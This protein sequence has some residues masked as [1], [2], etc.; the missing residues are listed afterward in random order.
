MRPSAKPFIALA[1][2]SVVLLLAVISPASAADAAAGPDVVT[3]PETEKRFPPLTVPEGFHATL[4]ACDPL[5][6]YPSVISVG[7]APGT[8]FVAHDYVT[9]LGVEI[10]RRDEIRLLRD[11]NGDGYA[12]QSTL[13]AGGFNSIQGL[14]WHGGTVY[15]MH[16]PLLTALR[17]TNSDGVA[18]ERRDLIRGLGLPPEENDNRLHCA[19][20]VAVGHDGWLYLALGDR[21]CDVVRP[22]GD[23]L[24]FQEGGILRCRAGGKLE[25]GRDL[26]VFSRGLRNIYDVAL[27]ADLNVFVRDNENDGG[28]Y[29][30]RVCHCFHGSNHGYPYLYRETPQEAMRPLA[31]LGRGSSAGGAAYLEAAFPED[32]RHSLF[33]CEWG[34]AVVRYPQQRSGSSFEPMREFDFAAGA[35]NDPYGFKPTDV[36][37]DRDGS[38][39]ISD[40]GDGQRPKRGRGRIYR[41]AYGAAAPAT[42]VPA[43]VAASVVTGESAL[44]ELL[45]RLNSASS[46]IRIEAQD[47]LVRRGTAGT[48]AVRQAWNDGTLQ[49]MGRLHAIWVLAQGLGAESTPVLLD[50]AAR[51]PEQRVRAQA[52]RAVA[53]LTDPVLVS[54]RLEAGRGEPAVAEQLAKLADG[55]SSEVRLETSI[56]LSRLHWA[57]G[58]AWLASQPPASDPALEHAGM[59]LLQKSGNWPAVLQLLDR[60][61]R[62]S[63]DA[64]DAR[65]L[66]LRELALRALALRALANQAEPVIVEGLISRLAAETDAERRGEYAGLLS[67]VYRKPAPWTYWGFRPAPRPANTVDWEQTAAIEQVFDRLLRDPAPQVRALAVRRMLRE[68]IPLKLS[69]LTAQWKTEQDEE[70]LTAILEALDVRPP[71]E[72]RELLDEIVRDSRRH[73]RHRL[74]ALASLLR[75]LDAGGEPRLVKLSMALDTGPVLAAVFRDLGKRSQLDAAVVLLPHLESPDDEVRCAA[76]EGIVN[77]PVPAA[78]PSV[79]KLLGDRDLRIRRA[80][81]ALAGKLRAQSAAGTLLEFTI[82]PDP[83]LRAASLTALHALREPRAVD[84]ALKSL[85][86]AETQVPAL[87]LLADLGGPA[88]RT[89]VTDVAEKTRS[90]EVLAAAVAALSQWRSQPA[91]PEADRAELDRSIARIQGTSGVALLW[92]VRGPLAAASAQPVLQ[93]LLASNGQQPEPTAEGWLPKIVQGTDSQLALPLPAGE[94]AGAVWL[95]VSELQVEQAENV[96]VLCSAGGSFSIWLNGKLVLQRPATAAFRPDSERFEASLLPGQN[97]F[98]VEIG[99]KDGN[100]AGQFHLRFRRKSSKAEHERITRS[101]LENRGNSERGRELFQNADKSLCVKCHRIGEQGGRIGP[102]LAGIGNRFSR[103]HLLE[104]ILEPSRTVAP[105]FST[106]VIA[107]ESG[108]VLAGVKIS[109]TPTQLTLGDNQGNRHEINKSEIDEIKIQP[110]STMPEDLQKRFSDRELLDLI[111]FLL[112]LKGRAP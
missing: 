68:N 38:L 99:V 56:A 28:D 19:N 4:F 20:G 42:T 8:V 34:R 58:P 92:R 27:D 102:D 79:A 67:R 15:V 33:F 51:D 66:A 17:D 112:S 24:L 106:Q 54:H 22:E 63:A 61:T 100:S 2:G 7:P 18:D 95:A 14:A 111:E 93:T 50:I 82:D 87:T 29:M 35:Q 103:I 10:V 55:A 110:Q 23:R 96:E 84:A 86:V 30:I 53:D 13:F 97:W 25:S 3:G 70:S 11:T 85:D 39:L 80:A 73:A 60:G 77:H 72:V 36:V 1:I 69:T 40:W 37:V 104:S 105:S 108:R 78:L 52:V 49:S 62:S 45:Q 43:P 46:W 48:Q 59:L 81:A 88:Q 101:V 89:A 98:V 31:D 16:A 41:I 65:E 9:G 75:G 6:E 32:Y 91:L 74:A 26:H 76:V 21:G 47:E 90:T 5:V 64:P 109:E 107:L 57:G 12:D 94:P 71:A 83:G 44:P